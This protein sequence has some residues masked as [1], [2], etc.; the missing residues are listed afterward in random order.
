MVEVLLWDKIH[1]T[2]FNNSTM[3]EFLDF[4]YNDPPIFNEKIE[5]F[6]NLGNDSYDGP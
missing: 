6:V 1:F 4:S 3:E 5:N 2:S